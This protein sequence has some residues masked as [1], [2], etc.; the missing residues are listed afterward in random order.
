MNLHE[1]EPY[2][3]ARWEAPGL[4]SCWAHPAGLGATTYRFGTAMEK[5]GV[6]KLPAL[7]FANF[8]RSQ[9][10]ICSMAAGRG[11]WHQR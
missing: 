3:A 1:E 4:R 8:K 6:E 9:S 7:T 2:S 11:I 5:L 10:I